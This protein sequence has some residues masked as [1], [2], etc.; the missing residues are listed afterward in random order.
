MEPKEL[1][2]EL[3]GVHGLSPFTAYNSSSRNYMFSSHLAQRL[4]TCEPDSK[5]VVTGLENK[6]SKYTF[7]IRMPSDGKILKVIQ[8][9]P[10]TIGST[11]LN[12]N[13]ETVVIYEDNETKTIDCF[14]IVDYKKFHQFFGY[15]YRTR[16]EISQIKSG[17]FIKKDTV[18]CS[19]PS[20]GD[21]N[22]F[23]YGFNAKVAFM[24][25]P[26]VSED[27]I[28]VRKGYLDKLKFKVYETRTIEFGISN[29][30]LNIYGDI[31][32]YKPFPDIGEYIRED[33]VLMALR[34]YDIGLIP[35]DTSI[36]DTR[37][38]DFIFDKCLFT[39]S[40]VGRV[41]DIKVHKNPF[42]PDKTPSTITTFLN[43]YKNAMYRFH[44]ELLEFE[45][46]LRHDNKSKYGIDKLKL[47]RNL[48]RLL[49]E[50][51]VDLDVPNDKF[52]QPLSLHNR[53]NTI[54]E[55]RIE[56]T[57]EYEI[58]PDIGFKLTC[59]SGGKG[60]ICSIEDDDKM[61][62]DKFGRRA[63][64]IL[65]PAATIS[66][67]NL[68]RLYEHYINDLLEQTEMK[69]KHMTGFK[70]SMSLRDLVKTDV[71]KINEALNYIL[72]LLE[73]LAPKQKD[74]I[75]NLTDSEKVEYLYL[76]MKEHITI[77]MPP[78][79]EIDLPEVIMGIEQSIY[80]PDVGPIVYTGHSGQ[81]TT[82]VNNIRIAD[83]YMMLLDK[84]ADDWSSVSI[85]K[86]QHFGIIS[87]Q[88]KS[89]KYSY[90]YRNSPVRTVGE[91]EGRVMVGFTP[92]ENTA[93]LMDRSNNPLTMRAM[94]QNIL[95]AEV[96]S[97]IDKL[98]NRNK[99]PYGS[100]K[101]LQ[102][103]NHIFNTAGFKIVYRKDKK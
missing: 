42:Q 23:N 37:E 90:P 50:A 95:D 62:V 9:Y 84:I 78:N 54:D 28:I 43:K 53:K 86:L 17:A 55:Y 32:N 72:G 94:V 26:A 13:P 2:L 59:N 33:G 36:Y 5:R 70:P 18:F 38:I 93:E 100:S 14:S 4:I 76:I 22:E 46:K 20:V 98:I 45:S 99:I 41:I 87:P 49:I 8:R 101:P 67:M 82:T 56:F 77:H 35:V 60:V 40:G 11:G 21:N 81:V 66:R 61:P 96:P 15:K 91:S 31:D 92:L 16:D 25:L 80:R 69:I 64:I 39:R 102:M 71:N 51:Y 58:K 12:Y 85:S 27:G 3:L 73:L 1:D 19:P 79:T 103:I 88:N 29:F 89:E 44:K 65:D 34:D 7:D 97:N 10:N 74:Y 57:I 30:P 68:G 75:M 6:F 47:G 24:T 63:D 52:R 48:H 83:F